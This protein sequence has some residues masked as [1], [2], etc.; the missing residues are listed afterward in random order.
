MG[1]VLWVVNVV[2]RVQP[3]EGCC[4]GPDSEGS[5]GEGSDWIKVIRWRGGKT[6]VDRR[7]TGEA[8]SPGGGGEQD[9]GKRFQS[10]PGRVIDDRRDRGKESK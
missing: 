5:V 1:D 10:S 6:V 3:D 9:E 2:S 4:Q 7:G 8:D